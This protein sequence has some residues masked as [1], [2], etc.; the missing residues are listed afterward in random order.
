M[1]LP[2]DGPQFGLGLGD[3]QRETRG[4]APEVLERIEAAL[5]LVENVD[6]DVGVIDDDPMAHRV[7][8]DGDRGD[9]VVHLEALLDFARNRLEMGLGGAAANHKKIR[10]AG[11]AP[12]V[13]GNEVFGLFIGGKFRAADS[14]FCPCQDEGTSRYN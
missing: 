2:L 13:D 8:I 5:L 3:F 1:G 9:F 12:Q 14:Q 6:D 11:D 4:V 10:E 7:A